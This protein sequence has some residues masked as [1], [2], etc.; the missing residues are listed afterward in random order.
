VERKDADDPGQSWLARLVTAID[1][2]ASTGWPET[3]RMMVLLVV[4]ALV[5]ALIMMAT[6]QAWSIPIQR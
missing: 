4:M 1:H 3:L 5:L 2:A 6:K